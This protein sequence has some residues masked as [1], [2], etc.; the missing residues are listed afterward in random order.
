M[1]PKR[2]T[3]KQLIATA[4]KLYHDEGS[5]EIDDA[6]KISMD[7]DPATDGAYVQAWVWVA[8][9]DAEFHM[10]KDADTEH[11]LN[12]RAAEV[13]AD[14]PEHATGCDCRACRPEL[15]V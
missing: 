2:P 9:D 15:Y 8:F 5:I 14:E 6:A 13:A 7:D 4:K 12:E 10:E 1:N 11:Y 3:D